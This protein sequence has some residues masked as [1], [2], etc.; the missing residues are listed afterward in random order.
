MALFRRA[1]DEQWEERGRLGRRA[2]AVQRAKRGAPTEGV[3]GLR[4]SHLR[5]VDRIPDSV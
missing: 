4:S 3:H 2:A 1:P 5:A